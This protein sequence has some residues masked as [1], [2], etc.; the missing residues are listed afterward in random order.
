MIK[1]SCINSVYLLLTIIWLITIIFIIKE[2][3]K[4]NSTN[5]L[6]KFFGVLEI[7]IFLCYCNLI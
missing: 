2:I 4:T 5:L 3:N 7:F 6:S 1:N